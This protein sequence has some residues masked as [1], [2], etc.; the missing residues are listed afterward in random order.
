MCKRTHSSLPSINGLTDKDAVDDVEEGEEDGNAALCYAKDDQ[1]EV[2]V[3]WNSATAAAA[4][5]R[6]TA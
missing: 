2:S 6:R 1:E 4:A 3:L 5:V